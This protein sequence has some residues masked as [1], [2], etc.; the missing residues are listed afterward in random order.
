MLNDHYYHLA[1]YLYDRVREHPGPPDLP[2]RVNKDRVLLHQ[3]ADKKAGY[4]GGVQSYSVDHN[5]WLPGGV[6][7][8]HD[9][10]K[11]VWGGEVGGVDVPEPPSSELVFPL[12]EISVNASLSDEVLL[13]RNAINQLADKQNL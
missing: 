6:V 2:T 4:K 8:L 11:S 13:H 12:P 9:F 3:T 5:R 1:Q 7:S 10:I